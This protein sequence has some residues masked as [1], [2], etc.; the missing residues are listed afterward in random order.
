VNWEKLK[1]AAS[2]SALA[3]L[4]KSM[5]YIMAE[6]IVRISGFAQ[7]RSLLNSKIFLAQSL[8]VLVGF[9]LTIQKNPDR[10]D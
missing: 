10:P 2:A 9:H 6:A 7:K 1:N 5:R 3:T 8:L 4:E